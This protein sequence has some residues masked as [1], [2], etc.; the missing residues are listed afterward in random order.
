MLYDLSTV[1]PACRRPAIQSRSVAKHAAVE[2]RFK[3][4]SCS[5]W[6]A[7]C[8]AFQDAVVTAMLHARFQIGDYGHSNAGYGRLRVD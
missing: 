5:Q 7:S 4:R 8:V 3:N 1:D 2:L 6:R